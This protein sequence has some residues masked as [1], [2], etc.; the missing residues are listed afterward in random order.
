MLDERKQNIPQ[1]GQKSSSFLHDVI[2]LKYLKRNLYNT[3]KYNKT[4]FSQNSPL[5]SLAFY[6]D[7]RAVNRSQNARKTWNIL[8]FLNILN[9]FCLISGHEKN[10]S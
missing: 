4:S 10:L 5:S 3:Y 2:Q 7:T 8:E 1:Q 6:F 9:H